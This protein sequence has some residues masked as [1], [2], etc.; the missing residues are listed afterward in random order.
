M[1]C[2]Y[3]ET[4]SDSRGTYMRCPKAC[5]CEV[6]PVKPEDKEYSPI[7]AIIVGVGLCSLIYVCYLLID[8]LA[9]F[10]NIMSH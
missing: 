4:F 7:L 8:A 6:E 1:Y 9:K 5:G 2:K 3:G 10:N